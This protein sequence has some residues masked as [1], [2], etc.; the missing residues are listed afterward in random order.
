[1]DDFFA[2]YG[3][4]FLVS[5]RKRCSENIS[6]IYP[7]SVNTFWVITC[8][9]NGKIHHV[10]TIMRIGQGGAVVDNAHA[11]GMFI[12]ISD[13]GVLRKSA[14]TEFLG[15]FDKH[16][17]TEITFK[18]YHINGSKKVLTAAQTMHARIPQVSVINWDFT[19]N[20]K[21]SPVLIEINIDLGG[22]IW[23]TQMANGVG[24]FDENP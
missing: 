14:F 6:A 16:S 17:G 23:M 18:N 7:H 20:E 4:D 9:W 21:E 12:G 2:L 19:L 8:I 10:P 15:R 22:S 1:M 24:P 3:K 5:E 13:D 11:G